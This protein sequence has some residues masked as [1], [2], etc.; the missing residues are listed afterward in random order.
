MTN[1]LVKAFLKKKL[2][3]RI[4]NI[5]ETDGEEVGGG[6]FKNSKDSDDNETSIRTKDVGLN[7]NILK[8]KK[9]RKFP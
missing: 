9:Y 3:K 5:S 7:L 1:K 2:K 8:R 4:D 6:K